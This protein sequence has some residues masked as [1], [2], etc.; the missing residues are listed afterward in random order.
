MTDLQPYF[1]TQCLIDI[2]REFRTPLSPKTWSVFVVDGVGSLGPWVWD[3]LGESIEDV[4]RG[5][6]VVFGFLADLDE[7]RTRLGAG[8]PEDLLAEGEFEG[9]LTFSPGDETVAVVDGGSLL[10]TRA[11]ISDLGLR[12]KS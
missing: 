4:R 10:R 1:G 8:D 5:N 7:L 6:L 12:P 11:T 9:I 3:H 2:Q